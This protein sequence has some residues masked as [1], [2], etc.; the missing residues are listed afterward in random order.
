VFSRGA[1]AG[2]ATSLPSVTLLLPSPRPWRLVQR[3]LHAETADAGNGCHAL[4]EADEA[5][6]LCPTQRAT[7]IL[8]APGIVLRVRR[9]AEH[10]YRADKT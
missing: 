6:I 1:D 4:R 5:A 2:D 8:R 10:H 7:T 9:S 3:V